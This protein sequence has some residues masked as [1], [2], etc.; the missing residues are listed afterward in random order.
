[1][2]GKEHAIVMCASS[3]L[4]G[5]FIPVHALGRNHQCFN[6]KVEFFH[7]YSLKVKRQR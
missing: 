3:V 6:V 4:E 7:G 5:S 1:M 2:G